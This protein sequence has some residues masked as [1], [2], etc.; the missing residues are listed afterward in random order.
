RQGLHEIRLDLQEK[1]IDFQYHP[2]FDQ[3]RKLIGIDCEIKTAD[4][5]VTKYQT[6][7]ADP[8]EKVIIRRTKEAGKEKVCLGKCDD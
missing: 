4:G 1:G 5:K 8:N 6:S 2:E 7:L 3:N